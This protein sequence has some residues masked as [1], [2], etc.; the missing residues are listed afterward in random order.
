MSID[1]ALAED[2][3]VL[4]ALPVPSAFAESVSGSAATT[5]QPGKWVQLAGSFGS[6]AGES[7]SPAAI[8]KCAVADVTAGLAAVELADDSAVIDVDFD[9]LLETA[10]VEVGFATGALAGA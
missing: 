5:S 8:E 6:V 1:G 9:F 3:V 7:L 10:A 2:P 4:V